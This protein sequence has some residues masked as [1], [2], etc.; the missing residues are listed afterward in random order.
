MKA[1]TLDLGDCRER[2][3]QNRGEGI[4][5][6]VSGAERPMDVAAHGVHMSI[7]GEDCSMMSATANLLYEGGEG[8]AFR[9]TEYNIVVLLPDSCLTV[10]ITPQEEHFVD[11]HTVSYNLLNI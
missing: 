10:F 1:S 7:D 8:I 5:E 9:L 2:V 6:R 11:F 3:N 4:V